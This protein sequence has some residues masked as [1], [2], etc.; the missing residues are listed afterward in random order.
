MINLNQLRVFHEATQN[1]NFT[2]AAKKLCIT[3]PPVTAHINS[4]TFLN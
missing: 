4:K 3:Q 2:A 1:M